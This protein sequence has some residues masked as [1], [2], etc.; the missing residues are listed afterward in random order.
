MKEG[1][2]MAETKAVS[3][4]PGKYSGKLKRSYLMHYIDAS[5]GSQTPSWFLP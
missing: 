4:T 3:G 1:N 2:I 5:F